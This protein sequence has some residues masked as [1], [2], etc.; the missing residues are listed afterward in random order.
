[1]KKLL[2]LCLTAVIILAMMPI[3]G[4]SAAENLVLAV[5]DVTADPGQEVT[6]TLSIEENPGVTFVQAKIGYMTEAFEVVSIETLTLAGKPTSNGPLTANPLSITWTDSLADTTEVGALA[7]ITFRVKEDVAPGKYVLTVRGV[8]DN[9]FNVAFDAVPFT[10][11]NGSITVNCLHKETTTHSAV[12]STC[13]EA[14]NEEYVTCNV[15][16]EVV[17]GSDAKLPLAD[18][19][20]VEV[21]EDKYLNTEATCT[22]K[23]TYFKSCSVCGIA[24]DVAFE[25][26]DLLEHTWAEVVDD[27]YLVSAATCTSKAVYNK[28]CS[29]CGVATDEP[30]EAGEVLPHAWAEVVADDYFATEATC[31]AKATYFKSCPDCG[32]VSDDTFEVGEFADHSYG[33]W[34]VAVKPTFTSTGVSEKV[35]SVCDDTVSEEIPVRI[36]AEFSVSVSDSRVAPGGEIDVVVSLDSNPG[37]T[38][39]SLWLDYDSTMFEIVEFVDAALDGRS[40]ECS[41]TDNDPAIIRWIGYDDSIATG[42]LVT[43]TF[44]VKDDA[45]DGVYDITLSTNQ[46]EV[47]DKDFDDVAYNLTNSSIKVSTRCPDDEHVWKQEVADEYL[48]TVATCSLKATYYLSCSECDAIADATF[49]AGE[50]DANNH[51]GTTT[52]HPAVE[53]TC[54]VA[55]NE[56][57]VT[58]DD[59]GA[60]VAG[61]DADLPLVDHVYIEVV[62]DEYLAAEATCT[63]VATYFVSCSECGEAGDDTFEVGEVLEHTWADVVADE[64]LISEANCI[65]RAVYYKSC[66]LCGETNLKAAFVDGNPIPDVHVGTTTI[67]AAVESTCIEA[68]NEEYVTCDDCG[69]VIE[70]SDAKLPLA[71]HT[72]AEVADEKY[73]VTEATCVS[74]AVYNKSCSVCGEASEETFEIGEAAGHAWVEVVADEYLVSEATCTAKATYYK[75]CSLCDAVSEET[76][77]AG[78]LAAHTYDSD[79]DYTCNA[80]TF[81]RAPQAPVIE[82]STT[83]SITLVATEGYEYSID[84]INWQSSNVF[85]NLAPQV[86]YTLYQRIAA[87]ETHDAS[88]KSE[89]LVTETTVLLG[90]VNADGVVNGKDTVILAQYVNGWDVEVLNVACDIDGDGVINGKDQTLLVRHLNGWDVEYFK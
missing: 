59:C 61:S 55:G 45:V 37:I 13:I 84:G 49:E 29:V 63:S 8:E 76:F 68:G 9:I 7:N 62:A 23:S 58:C 50:F 20:W 36:P 79:D 47:F 51:V 4:V 83:V 43:I 81:T 89:A 53:S 2:A 72:W 67:H 48:A 26:G 87:T 60:V 73:L 35:C 65:D 40:V 32:A 22:D 6:V 39:A 33:D 12:E 77:E 78:E 57:Y 31:I 14:G 42:T 75:S 18:H 24:S 56:E 41:E 46:D 82:S 90:D 27:K 3:I 25:T 44:R 19:T 16:G 10:T 85:E 21:V 5:N 1:M 38:G 69:A 15:C 74:N 64:Y 66:S 70:G 30:F 88:D 52:T 80:C 28:S 17:E 11:T 54:T 86:E 34:F 71:E